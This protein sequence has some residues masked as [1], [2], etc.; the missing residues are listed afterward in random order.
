[1][2]TWHPGNALRREFVTV[3]GRLRYR[4]PNGL[5]Y[6]LA[7][8]HPFYFT[9]LLAPLLLPGLWT[10]VRLRHPALLWLIVGWAAVVYGFHAGAPWQNFRFTL[11]YLP[12]LAVLVAIGAE[13]VGRIRG[14]R[15]PVRPTAVVGIYLAV[16]LLVMGIGGVRLTQEFI[17]RKHADLSVVRWVEAQV[18]A[19]AR[20]LTFGLTLTF[21]HYS[22]LETLELFELTP[23]KLAELL[24]DG[25]AT[26]LLLDI[27]NVE[28]QWRGR[29][30]EV[31]YRWLREG[32]G[33]ERLGAQRGY[34]LFRVG[35]V[36]EG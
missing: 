27:T 9:P 34:V 31:N 16:G 4:L 1:V 11:A 17:A 22:H 7:P 3:D 36:D 25:R 6:A 20:L 10:V 8:A 28:A 30:P 2:Y 13:T 12:P 24:A 33:L 15:W 14:V 29:A 18:P 26:F 23:V 21:R 32:P 5:Y 35:E 19:D